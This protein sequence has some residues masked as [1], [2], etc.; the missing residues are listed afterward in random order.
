ME[1]VA[2]EAETEKTHDV[3]ILVNNRT[4]EVPRTTTG[5]GIKRAAGVP[6]DYQVFKIQGHDEIPV[7]DAESIEVH[8]G[9]RFAATP[10]IEPA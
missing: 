3:E 5:A 6:A 8:K 7:G 10:S 9:G 1:T 2:A 4:V